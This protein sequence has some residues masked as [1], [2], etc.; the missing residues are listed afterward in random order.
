[1]PRFASRPHLIEAWQFMGTTASL[2]LEI[3]RNV[4][5]RRTG[6][7]CEMETADGVRLCR[8]GAWIVRQ[9]G[10]AVMHVSA[11][12]FPGL[13]EIVDTVQEASEFGVRAT[14]V[15]LPGEDNPEHVDWHGL[16]FPLNRPVLV[17]DPATIEFSK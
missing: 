14:F 1:M 9:E 2:P 15:G 4:S 13:Y 6:D 12:R 3:A 11:A 16:R 5:N 7:G 10:G 17:S 8:P